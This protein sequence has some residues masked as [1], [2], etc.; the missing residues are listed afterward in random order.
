MTAFTA[1]VG[2]RL[3][4]QLPHWSPAPPHEETTGEIDAMALYAGMG[5]GNVARVEPAAD[6]VAEL[7]RLL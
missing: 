1:L 7:V 4:V 5:V 2:C 3:P 6:I